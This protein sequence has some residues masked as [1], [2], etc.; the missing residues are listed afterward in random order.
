MQHAM[1]VA[2]AVVLQAMQGLL[3]CK[4]TVLSGRRTERELAAGYCMIIAPE[5]RHRHVVA[6]SGGD[7][8]RVVKAVA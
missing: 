2:E 4:Q 3:C 8:A 6:Q 7:H 5:N 1:I